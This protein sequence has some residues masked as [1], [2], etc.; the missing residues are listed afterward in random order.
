MI[1]RQQFE[2]IGVHHS[3]VLNEG[4][5][6]TDH[7]PYPEVMI[8]REGQSLT[9]QEQVPDEWFAVEARLH[10][11]HGFMGALLRI[12]LKGSL[13]F[14]DEDRYVL[15]EGTEQAEAEIAKRGLECPWRKVK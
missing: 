11:V 14:P 8:L 3:L 1:A 5:Q 4:W 10:P 6:I 15:F 2:Q 12:E 13:F 9:I 7:L